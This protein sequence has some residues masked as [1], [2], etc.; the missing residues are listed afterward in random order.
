MTIYTIQ[1]QLNIILPS[2]S[3]SSV[4]IS[5]SNVTISFDIEAESEEE[6]IVQAELIVERQTYLSLLD[7]HVTHVEQSTY[8]QN[9][10]AYTSLTSLL[11]QV[12][13]TSHPNSYNPLNQ[14]NNSSYTRL[15]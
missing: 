12:N 6:A 4:S 8:Q 9:V 1:A 14:T 15:T 3:D 2:N 13:Q 11:T 10:S 5:P 7:P